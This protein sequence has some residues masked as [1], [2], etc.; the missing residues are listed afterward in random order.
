MRVPEPTARSRPWRQMWTL[1]V[2]CL[3]VA[4]VMAAVASLTTALPGLAGDTGASQTQ[5]T[6]I[7]DAYTLVLACAL[8]P[9]GA[10]GDRYGRRGVLVIGLVVFAV[11]SAL[12]TVVTSPG[13]VIACRAVSGLGAALV[14]PATLSILTAE[15]PPRQASRAVGVWAGFAGAGAVL[16]ILGAGMLLQTWSWRAVFAATAILALL[17]LAGAFAVP[18]SREPDTQPLDV[19]GAALSATAIG[20]VVFGMI[21]APDRG[22]DSV[23]VIGALSGAVLAA[24]GFI[25]VERRH[26][27]PLLDVR[28]FTE[29]AFG[30]GAGS[31]VVQFLA[32]FG[33]FF[34]VMQHL[35]LVWN[36]S[37]L[38]AG[39]AL[40]PMAV[41]LV[42][43]AV[44]APWLTERLGLRLMTCTGLGLVAVALA[45][46]AGLGVEENY[47][48]LA[49]FIIMFG[50]GLGISAT[51]ATAAIVHGVPRAKQGVASAVND[52][53]REIGAALGI[54]LAGSLLASGY[55]TGIMLD[56]ATL[57]E[58]DR[59]L[60][61]DS[62]TAALHV[63]TTQADPALAAAARRAFTEGMHDSLLTLAA[64]T[65]T[66]TIVLALRA[67][68]RPR[69]KPAHAP[70]T[71]TAETPGPSALD[72]S[73]STS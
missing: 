9:A 28:L 41:P 1:T 70:S 68:G 62:L 44:L 15:F 25:L 45:G 69:A 16:G 61:T 12:P 48:R 24:A 36:Y 29:R 35:Q 8:L 50:L 51:P 43:V 46:V 19:P 3:A 56:A 22:W 7:V 52:A 27:A 11:G 55:R 54:A 57:P 33:L 6:W 34:V 53:T 47:P 60:A 59:T 30:T 13:W 71:P 32:A 64:V 67:P 20:L 42:V 21:E 18:P 65:A 40:T 72:Q 63:A 38:D 49:V 39:L 14:M 66:A 58:P 73:R 23:L 2:S 17:L 10:V 4:L 26:R 31:L 5:L 37:P